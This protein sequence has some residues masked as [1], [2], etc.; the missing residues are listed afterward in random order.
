M[1]PLQKAAVRRKAFY[2]AAILALFTVSIFYRGLEAKTPDGSPY[3]WMPFGRD[4]RTTRVVEPAGVFSTGG[5]WYLSA[6]CHL[7]GAERVFRIDRILAVVAL[8]TDAC[9]PA[10]EAKPA[11]FERKGEAGFVRLLL[12]P[13]AAWVVEQYPVEEVD[14]RGTGELEVTLAVSEWS[15]LDRLVLRLGVSVSVLAAPPGW[16]GAAVA[17]GRVLD[18]YGRNGSSAG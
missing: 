5:Q 4:D 7:A 6:Y 14:Q 9:G 11:L 1:N 15:W 13:E 17:A 3:V 16:S 10:V 18:R 12:S 2:L 8:G